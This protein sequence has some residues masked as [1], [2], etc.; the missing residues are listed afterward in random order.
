MGII[1]VVLKKCQPDF[2]NGANTKNTNQ[3]TAFSIKFSGKCAA[4]GNWKGDRVFAL[5]SLNFNARWQQIPVGRV[6][7][8]KGRDFRKDGN[9]FQLAFIRIFQY[10]AQQFCRQ[11]FVSTFW[12]VHAGQENFAFLQ[13]IFDGRELAVEAGFKLPGKSIVLD[14]HVVGLWETA[15]R[16]GS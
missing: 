13:R 6:L 5:E 7:A 1:E 16:R 9:D 14:F 10:G 8:K 4:K 2:L 15:K 11:F 3:T 12:N